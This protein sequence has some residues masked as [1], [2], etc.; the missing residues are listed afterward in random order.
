[1]WNTLRYALERRGLLRPAHDRLTLHGRVR[2][3]DDARTGLRTTVSVHLDQ[4]PGDMLELDADNRFTLVLPLRVAVRLTIARP[5]HLPRVVEIR[6]L[7]TALLFARGHVHSS[8]AID[9]VLTSILATESGTARPLLERITMPRDRKPLI[10]EWDHVLRPAG[11]SGFEPL[12][13]RIQ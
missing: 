10:V 5:D 2:S 12:F 7:R 1:M 4:G 13:A 11:E 8:C 6:P 3:D 9:V